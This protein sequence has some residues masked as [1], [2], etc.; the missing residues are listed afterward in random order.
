M[1]PMP[2]RRRRPLLLTHAWLG[3]ILRHCRYELAV[4]YNTRGVFATT[5]RLQARSLQGR[6]TPP[7]FNWEREQ[8]GCGADF[9]LIGWGAVLFLS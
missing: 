6:S 8:E 1:K 3:D 9:S 4:V 2:L 5:A 7:N